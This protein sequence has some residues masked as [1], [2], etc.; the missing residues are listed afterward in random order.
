MAHACDTP[1]LLAFQYCPLGASLGA[2]VI[3]AGR[4]GA[5]G[6]DDESWEPARLIPVSGISGAEEQERRG[7]S[8]LLAVIASVKEF[9]RAVTAPLGAPAGTVATFIEVPF[10]VGERDVRPDG[11]IRVTR[12]K[13]TWTA[14]VEVK[15]GPNDLGV[16]QLETYLDVAREQGFD[17]VLTISNQIV[18]V[19]GEHP[20]Q[21]DK[22]RLRK[23]QLFHRSWSEIHTEAVIER[24]NRSIADLDQA[25]ILSELIRY[26]EHERSGAVDLKD[27]GPSWVT[28]RNAT[29]TRT[30]RGTDKGATEVVARFGQLIAFAAMRLAR[31]LGVSVRPALS[32]AEMRDPAAYVQAGVARLVETGEMYGA[33]QVPNAV[34]PIEVLADVRSG[35]ITCSISVQ[36]PATG[37][38][39]TRVNWL[40]RQ[41]G[42]VPDKLMIEAWS[43]WARTPGPCHTI[44]DVREKPDCLFDDPKKELRS[45]TITLSATAGT[46]GGHGRGT[47]V[48]SVLSLVDTFYEAVVQH[49]RHWTPPAPPVP[50]RQGDGGEP[51]RDDHISGEL[52]LKSVQRASGPPEWD[53]PDDPAANLNLTTQTA[54]PLE[55]SRQVADTAERTDDSGRRGVPQGDSMSNE[56]SKGAG[57][58][59]KV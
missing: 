8:A 43:A 51:G 14:I 24:V 18:A 36:A 25:W 59:G 35:L 16:A 1:G 58:G 46:K 2:Q 31:E 49:L 17:A 13:Q 42:E 53:P 41:L 48:G 3:F 38:N 19:P 44:I 22:R 10:K 21:V 27:M 23:V 55:T 5:L 56:T 52:P 54:P 32:R 45:F 6:V 33:I 40:I 37:R 11:V 20:T 28:V 26:L 12:G 9:G 15:T 57:N 30:L 4:T 7:V 47:F 50:P 39:T 34:G 29:T